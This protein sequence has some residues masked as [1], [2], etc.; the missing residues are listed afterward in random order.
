MSNL[1][2]KTGTDISLHCPD[3]FMYPFKIFSERAVGW[4]YNGARDKMMPL[5]QSFCLMTECYAH[6]GSKSSPHPLLSA[7]KLLFNNPF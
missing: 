6:T 3:M 2:I 1:N 4:N 7:P 5:V